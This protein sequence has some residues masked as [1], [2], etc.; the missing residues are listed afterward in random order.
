MAL[1]TVHV[2]LVY[3]REEGRLHLQES[4]E[5]STIAMRRRFELERLPEYA[6]ME[7]VV[8]SADSVE[9][10]HET[11]GRYFYTTS[12]LVQKLRDAINNAV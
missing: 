10:L 2:V 11:H 6:D 5:D 1:P 8:L 3:Q 9:I 12:Q 4:Y 7:V